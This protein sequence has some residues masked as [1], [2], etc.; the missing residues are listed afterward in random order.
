M[1]EIDLREECLDPRAGVGDLEEIGEEP[2]V[3]PGRH[4]RPDAPRMLLRHD[5]DPPPKV[6]PRRRVALTEEAYLT[7]GRGG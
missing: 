7:G 3:V 6:E 2:Q 1:V 4:P 5:T